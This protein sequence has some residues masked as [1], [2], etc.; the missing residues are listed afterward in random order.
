MNGTYYLN[1]NGSR[2]VVYDN[3]KKA[4][5]QLR[6]K[7]NNVIERTVIYYDSFGNFACALIS[8]KGKKVKVLC[9]EV[10]PD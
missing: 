8:Y 5:I 2:W 3:G 4:K 6:T 1:N 7:S 10:L 9:D